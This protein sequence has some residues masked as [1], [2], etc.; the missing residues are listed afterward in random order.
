MI[1]KLGIYA[2]IL[3]IVGVNPVYAGGVMFSAG[4]VASGADYSDIIFYDGLETADS[5]KPVLTPTSDSLTRSTNFKLAGTYSGTYTSS[6]TNGRRFSNVADAVFDRIE[7]RVGL[8]IRTATSITDDRM[9]FAAT[10]TTGSDEVL[11]IND[12]TTGIEIRWRGQGTTQ[13][14]YTG[15]VLT[16]NTEYYLEFSYDATEVVLYIDGVLTSLTSSGTRTAMS[17]SPANGIIAI[18]SNG[19]FAI[20]TDQYMDQLIISDDK[21]RDINAVKTVTDFN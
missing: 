8:W 13:Q 16:P 11:L 6:V 18:G 14:N 10:Y 5:D 19:T 12:G 7:G 1:N 15:A 9:Y 17:A 4:G 2:L 3:L 21:T 20:D